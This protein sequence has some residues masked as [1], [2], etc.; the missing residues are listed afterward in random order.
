MLYSRYYGKN[1]KLLEL[2]AEQRRVIKK[3]DEAKMKAVE[4]ADRLKIEAKK[5]SELNKLAMEHH[6]SEKAEKPAK[7]APN[8]NLEEA[9]EQYD[10]KNLVK[11]INAGLLDL[12]IKKVIAMEKENKNRKSVLKALEKRIK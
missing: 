4:H 12:G 1:K 6:K 11:M 3:A 10:A 9:P 2:Q 5:R 7:N 8:A